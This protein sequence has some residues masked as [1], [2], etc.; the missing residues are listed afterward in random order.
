MWGGQSLR[1]PTTKKTLFYVCLPLLPSILKLFYLEIE[2]TF[3]P[4]GECQD[5]PK[6]SRDNV[7]M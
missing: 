3:M 1:G 4:L 6:S 5:I 2:V 7:L